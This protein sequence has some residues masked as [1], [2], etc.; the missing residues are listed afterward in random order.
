MRDSAMRVGMTI[1]LIKMVLNVSLDKFLIYNRIFIGNV[2]LIFAPMIQKI[3]LTLILSS[4]IGFSFAQKESKK[5]EKAY[6]AYKNAILNDNGTEAVKWVDSRTI[7]YY[8]E[9]LELVRNADSL[10]V[11]SLSAMDKLMVFSI[12]HRA[13]ADSIRNFDGKAM[14][15]Y[16]IDNG[17][18][19]KNSVANFDLGKIKIDSAFAAAEITMG[20][21]VAPIKFHFYNEDGSWKMDITALFSMSRTAFRRMVT[22]SQEE[23]NAYLF[24]LLEAVSGKK[25]EPSIWKPVK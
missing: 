6:N 23:E 16:A 9:V 17:M 3:A 15:V 1:F 2:L 12:R 22:N 19:G 20:K 10:A 8:S 13:P 14:L 18:V 7:K 24:N 4:F 21:R 25:P 5:V 11:D